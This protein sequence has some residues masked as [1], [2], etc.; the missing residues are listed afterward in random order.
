MIEES[1]YCS[2][3]K[4]KHFIK[5]LVMNKEDD[6]DFEEFTKYWIYDNVYGDGD[7]KV[8]DHCHITRKYRGSAH[9][10]CNIKVK[11]KHKILLVFHNLKV[12]ILILLRKN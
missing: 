12:M 4:K 9:R 2:D 8:R 7:V 1:K 10:D 6:E 5:E 3:V 11:L